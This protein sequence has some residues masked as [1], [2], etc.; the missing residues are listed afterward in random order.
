MELALLDTDTLSEVLRHRNANVAGNS[1]RYLT[2][3]GEFA[4][5]AVTHYEIVRGLLLKEA[6]RKLSQFSKF[7]ERAIIMPISTEVLLRAAELWVAGRRDGKPHRD[8]DLVIASTALIHQ[9]RLITG[10]TMHFDWIPG[11]TLANWRE[12]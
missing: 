12:P 4:F 9:R 1:A 5:S 2:E 3:Y 7:A 8:A 6:D 11:L 10:N